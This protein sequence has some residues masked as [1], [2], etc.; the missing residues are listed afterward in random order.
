ME[1]AEKLELLNRRLND[2]NC[3]VEEMSVYACNLNSIFDHLSN[4]E[5]TDARITIYRS[6]GE[7]SISI[8]SFGNIN[9]TTVFLYKDGHIH[10]GLS[11]GNIQKCKSFADYADIEEYGDAMSAYPTDDFL[12][13]CKDFYPTQSFSK[14]DVPMKFRKDMEELYATGFF[15]KTVDGKL[16]LSYK[17]KLIL[18][19]R[20]EKKTFLDGILI[21]LYSMFGK[22]YRRFY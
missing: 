13:I 6:T 9:S 19:L 14:D 12:R 7:I 21:M 18:H 8:F 16:M 4:M 17:A 3:T 20:Y 22:E 5:W 1:K 15:I 2:C 10:V 11:S